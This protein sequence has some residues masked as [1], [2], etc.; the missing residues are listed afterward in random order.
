M[1]LTFT[2]KAREMETIIGDLVG[3]Q[4]ARYITVGTFPLD[5]CSLPTAPLPIA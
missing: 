5:L 2:N 1:A 3:F 4:L